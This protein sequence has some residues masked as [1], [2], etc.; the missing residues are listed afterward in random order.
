MTPVGTPGLREARL[1]IAGAR[2]SL[3]PGAGAVVRAR[4]CLLTDEW[5]RRLWQA[6]TVDHPDPIVP[7]PGLALACTGSLARRES[8]PLS[9]L[10]LALILDARCGLD[11][12]RLNELASRLW[13]PIWDTRL[14]LDHGVHTVEEARAL[15]GDDLTV[16]ASLLDIRPIAGD[17][18]VITTLRTALAADWRTGARRRLPE[19]GAALTTRHERFGDLA[20]TLDPDL[21]EA[22]GGLRDMTML[23][24]LAAS[25]LADRPH[26]HPDLAH[27]TLLDVRDMVQSVTGRPRNV[28]LLQDQDAVAE[29]LGT[30]ADD[31]LRQVSLAGRTIASAL[32]ATLRRALQARAPRRG[33]PPRRPAL[34]PLGQGCYAYEGEV[35]LGRGAHLADPALPLIAAR[36]AADRGLE[37]SPVTAR[38]LARDVPAP[39]VP[40]P[41]SVRRAFVGF[42]TAGRGVVD[43]WEVLDQAG[44]VDRWLP[45]WEPIRSRPQR[46]SVH[47]WTVDR[48]CVETAVL[49]GTLTDR[50]ARPDLLVV[51]AL[52]HDIG[53]RPGAGDHSRA[54]EPLARQTCLDLGFP[55]ADADLVAL[56]VREHLTLID[57]ATRDD[58][59]SPDVL[60]RLVDAVRAD[61]DVLAL[62]AALTE[63]DARATGPAA[64]SAWR[65]ERL[66]TFVTA[67]RARIGRRA[68][69]GSPSSA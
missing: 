3:S 16:T 22:H 40:W 39:T 63:A 1:D 45:V 43:A 38:H 66:G 49:A 35:V 12:D 56:L 9:D 28:L 41:E 34:T 58:P 54:G 10:D 24:A 64:W 65:A 18:S 60:D 7:G 25:W 53:K 52:L 51:T 46:N 68:V 55:E 20:Q 29:R 30:D 8:G 62:L 26:G 50:V 17:D 37:L 2:G 33:L 48:H 36:I 31:L 14:G 15:A 11:P 47:R 21:K 6:A 69:E 32:D 5:L 19:F 67:V 61:P 57:A 42:L 4:I 27:H 13:Y 44:L 23:R 59:T